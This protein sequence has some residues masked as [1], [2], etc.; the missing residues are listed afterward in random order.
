MVITACIGWCNVGVHDQERAPM[1]PDPFPHER[2]GS[3]DETI[4]KE[5]KDRSTIGIMCLPFAVVW[6]RSC[7]NCWEWSLKMTENVGFIGKHGG[8]CIVVCG[9]R[10]VWGH[11]PR[12]I[13]NLQP[14][15]LLLRHHIYSVWFSSVMVNVYAD[16]NG[17]CI[18][19]LRRKSA[20][21]LIRE[22]STVIRQ[23][24]GIIPRP[25]KRNLAGWHDEDSEGAFCRTC[26]NLGRSLH[27]YPPYYIIYIL[28]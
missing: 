25:G 23:V 17:W 5:K 22:R 1:S 4:W 18:C 12:K 8:L 3:G 16:V 24:R 9:S 26:K 19:H 10:G 14:L 21:N 11:A 13:Y 6:S 20:L 27:I 15:R 2:V 28:Y 7:V